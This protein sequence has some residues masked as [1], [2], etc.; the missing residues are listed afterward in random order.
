MRT[1]SESETSTV[2]VE[3]TATVTPT[4]TPKVKAEKPK[5]GKGNFPAVPF[6]Y[7]D[8][9]GKETTWKGRGRKPLNLL[10]V[11]E[12]KGLVAK[13]S[14]QTGAWEF[15]APKQKAEASA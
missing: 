3:E 11:E 8:M 13:R 1:E 12:K 10:A 7:T 15:I 6:T 4:K 2:A 14:N 5:I 9:E